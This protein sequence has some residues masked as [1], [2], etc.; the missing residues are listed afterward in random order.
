MVLHSGYTG[1]RDDSCSKQ[2]GTGWHET[3]A[4][5]FKFCVS[6]LSLGQINHGIYDFKEGCFS[7]IYVFNVQSHS[8]YHF[9][10]MPLNYD[11]FDELIHPWVQ[12]PMIQMTQSSY[13]SLPSEPSA[14]PG[15]KPSTHEPLGV[16]PNPKSKTDDLFLDKSNQGW[17]WVT[18]SLEQQT[19]DNW[20][21]ARHG[22]CWPRFSEHRYHLARPGPTLTVKT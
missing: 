7:L 13:K 16:V 2:G 10:M 19:R 1:P 14:V 20:S 22:W 11:L 15:T 18:E 17:L 21:I 12:N 4:T 5:Q 8:F 6:F 9:P 3:G